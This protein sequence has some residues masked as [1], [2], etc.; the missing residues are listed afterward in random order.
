MRNYRGFKRLFVSLLA[1][2]FGCLALPGA[3]LAT[4]VCDIYPDAISPADLKRYA[5]QVRGPLPAT[6][7]RLLSKVAI[8]NAD[9]STDR[10][11]RLLGP[12][13]QYLSVPTIVVPRGYLRLNCQVAQIGR[14]ILTGEIT[15][16]AAFRTEVTDC[17]RR[18]KDHRG[19]MTKAVNAWADRLSRENADEEGYDLF[20]RMWA[21][22]NFQFSLSH[23]AA[24]VVFQASG[25]DLLKV[26][27]EEAAADLQAGIAMAARSQE[28]LGQSP[29]Y[30]VAGFA[31]WSVLD[32]T[33][34]WTNSSHPSYTCRMRSTEAIYTKVF[35]RVLRARFWSIDRDAFED[36][37]EDLYEEDVVPVSD[38]PS[39]A[40]DTQCPNVSTQ[41]LAPIERD[42]DRLLAE[43]EK[44][45]PDSDEIENPV[46]VFD[47]LKKVKLETPTV[48]GLRVWSLFMLSPHMLKDVFGGEDRNDEF[49]DIDEDD[50]RAQRAAIRKLA[51]KMMRAFSGVLSRLKPLIDPSALNSQEYVNFLVSSEMT[52]AFRYGDLTPQKVRKWIRMVELYAPNQGTILYLNGI[53]AFWE[54]RCADGTVLMQQAFVAEPMLAGQSNDDGDEKLDLSKPLNTEQ[55]TQFRLG[56]R[57]GLDGMLRRASFQ[58]D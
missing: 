10:F 47:A 17:V 2:L 30:A 19:C 39:F 54:G 9:G 26:M 57:E 55:C 6:H 43:M 46:G 22:N 20:V 41:Q 42:L 1:I 40:P 27:D 36:L 16:V 31:V 37:S 52:R 28:G 12:E 51:S 11:N 33:V 44:Q 29:L 7:A 18:T 48:K 15:D 13:V 25:S 3:A 34:D 35:P 49:D 5:D 38:W 58:S 4:A 50:E 32:P 53:I 14:A 45:M 56:L 21:E 8:V 24:H 23:E